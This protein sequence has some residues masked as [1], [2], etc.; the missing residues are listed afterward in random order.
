MGNLIDFVRKYIY[1]LVFLVLEVVSLVL[2]IQFNGYQGSVAFSTANTVVG[3]VNS[4]T[5]SVSSYFSLREENR[6][7]EAANQVLR[8]RLLAM[9]QRLAEGTDSA[10]SQLRVGDTIPFPYHVISAQVVNATVHR[11]HNLLTID[12]GE[13]DG[14]RPEMGVVSSNGVVG[15]VYLTSSHYS[16]VIPL[17]NTSTQISCR[18]D[19]TRYFG[20]MQWQHGPARISY[21]NGIPRHAKVKVGDRIVTNGYS[22]IFPEGIPIGRVIKVGDSPDGMAYGLTVHLFTDFETLRNVSVITDYSHPER[23][24]LEQM[25]DSI[26]QTLEQ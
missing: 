8:Q 3:S 13:A 7:L 26:V 2:L 24:S 5:S 25:A 20:T 21:V 9:E 4:V 6:H 19:T 11:A 10:V 14:I 17:V 12:R 15:V 16:I 1:W 18:I 23:K 22:D